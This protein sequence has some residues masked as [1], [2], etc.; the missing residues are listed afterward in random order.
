MS[1]NKSFAR[2]V[3]LVLIA[4]AALSIAGAVG[5]VAMHRAAEKQEAARA[6]SVRQVEID[7]AYDEAIEEVN[8]LA[9]EAERILSR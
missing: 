8:G 2:A 5:A 3:A 4:V 9:E 1:K 6:K 7:A